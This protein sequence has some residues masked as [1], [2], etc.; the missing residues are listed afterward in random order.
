[1]SMDPWAAEE[2]GGAKLGDGRLTQRLI[3]VASAFA[4][5]PTASIPGACSGWAETQA[6]YRFFDQASEKKQGLGW[7]DVLTPHM[8]C[9]LARMH[10][11]RV[12]LCLQDTTELDFNGQSIPGTGTPQ[13]R[14]PARPVS[15]S[16][17][18]RHPEREPLGI[19]DAWIWA[20]EF[21]DADGKRPGILESTRWIEGYERVAEAAA[22]M[23][24]TR[25][26]YV[27]DREGD[28][29]VCCSAGMRWECPLTCC[30]VP[31]TIAAFPMGTSCGR[32]SS[33]AKV[34]GE[35]EFTLPARGAQAARLVRQ[36]LFACRVELSDGQGGRF[37]VTCVIAQEIG[38]PQRRQADRM[39]SAD[40]SHRRKPRSGHRTD[41]LVSRQVGN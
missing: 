20:R 4:D 8:E 17:L 36:Q 25:L 31:N 40:Q 34:L 14:D 39:A 30:C 29:I 1:M 21:K 11:H 37:P 6:T 15:A 33:R 35:I 27:G 26:V 41:Q 38:A 9:T 10:S 24:D 5:R 32:K 23:P 12:V 19:L 28:I 13:L 16:H 3:Q 18:C 2:F 7:E 22:R